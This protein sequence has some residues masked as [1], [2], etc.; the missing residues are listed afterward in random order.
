MKAGITDVVLGV[1][2]LGFTDPLSPGKRRQVERAR[3]AAGFSLALSQ[4]LYDAFKTA[5]SL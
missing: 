2:H 1:S 4:C 5:N 3:A